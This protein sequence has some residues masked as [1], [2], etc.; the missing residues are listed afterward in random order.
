VAN[1]GPELE[2]AHGG[3]RLRGFSPA[4]R[5]GLVIVLIAVTYVVT[6]TVS[7]AYAQAVIVLIQLLAVWIV[8]GVSESPRARRIAGIALAVGA[9]LAVT[10]L[11]L[12]AVGRVDDVLR[13]LSVVSALLY[14]VAPVIITRHIARTSVIDRESVLGAIAAYLL[15]GM[16]FA[17]CYEA[18]AAIQSTPPF[19]GERGHG[20]PSNFLFFSFTTLT[21]TGYGDLVPAANPGQSI[22]V[23]EAIA[24]QLFLVT[25]VAKIVAAWRTPRER[26]DEQPDAA[27]PAHGQV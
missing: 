7:G 21:T 12:G 8:F 10:G 16:M 13:V 2:Q 14:L 9:L 27:P 20:N 25:A 23:L 6:V 4:N 18:V 11:I 24:G 1:P 15:L 19:F 17:Y 3:S 22:A 5:Y 26:G